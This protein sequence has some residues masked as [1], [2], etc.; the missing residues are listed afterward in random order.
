MNGCW[1]DKNRM[2]WR[3]EDGK[4]DEGWRTEDRVTKAVGNRIRKT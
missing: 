3:T 4:V 2:G 1:R